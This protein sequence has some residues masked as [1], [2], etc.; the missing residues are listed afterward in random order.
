MMKKGRKLV[1]TVIAVVLALL[2]ASACLL[3]I[4]GSPL[5][6]WL[7]LGETVEQPKGDTTKVLD[8]KTKTIIDDTKLSDKEKRPKLIEAMEE[9]RER[10]KAEGNIDKVIEMDMNI[11]MMKLMPTEPEPSTTQPVEG[12]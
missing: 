8:S 5:R 1:I 2:I 7:G 10:Y 3:L 12:Q 4:P 6:S 9:A 11:E